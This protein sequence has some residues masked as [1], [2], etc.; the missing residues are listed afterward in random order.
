MEYAFLYPFVAYLLAAVIVVPI[1]QRLG[2]GGVLGYLAAGVCI[3]PWGLGLV[4][5]VQDILHISELGVV[6]LLFLIGLELEPKRLWTMRRSIFGGGGLQVASVS[7]ALFGAALLAGFAWQ[8]ALVAAL[9]LSLSSTAIALA[10]LTERNLLATPAG[11]AGFSILLFQDIAAIPMIAIVPLLGVAA[12]SHA[13]DLPGWLKALQILGVVALLVLGGRTILRPI[14]RII[15]RTNLR[16][17]F[18]AFALLLVI[19]IGLIMHQVGMSMAMGT[20]IAGVLLADSE[21][22]RAL[23]ADLEPFKGLLLGLF[24][25]A[26]GMT[27]DFG[28]LFSQPFKVLA[29]LIG[30]LTIKI[31]V[32]YLLGMRLGVPTNQRAMF[33]ILLAQGSEFAF[34]VFGAA[35][36]AKVFSEET[37]AMLVLVVALSLMSTP[38]LLVLHDKLLAPRLASQRERKADEIEAR[39]G[40]VIIAGFGRFGQ[41]VG[42]LLR[43]HQVPLTVLDHDPDQV[44][45]LRRFGLEVFYGDATRLDLLR[46]ARAD[47]ARA[48]VVAIDGVEESLKLVEAAREAFP[49]LTILARARNVSHYYDLMDRGVTLIERETF[50]SALQLGRE[51]LHQLGFGAY[52][53]REAAMK[54]RRHNLASLLKV[55]PVYKDQEQLVSMSKQARDELEQ[56]FA[57]DLEA[58]KGDK[59]EHNARSW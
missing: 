41:I 28:V 37:S 57:S 47:K 10:S 30:F 54:F 50:D 22:R 16:E 7:A 51:V 44:D 59:G 15:A 56:M 3:G 26:V 1:V 33:A 46:A 34:V 21:Y 2:L 40:H 29:V 14:L 52:F 32:L 27:V 19:G 17:I 18:T 24:F 23:E 13:D 58:L 38:L 39:E 55:Y 11:G 20:F 25:M 45:L 12:A 42:R 48:L 36:T 6:L 53:A 31:A 43:A 5:D 49:E 8:T 9:G 35:A 4:R